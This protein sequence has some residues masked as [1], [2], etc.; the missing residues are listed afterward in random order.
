M[1]LDANGNLRLLEADVTN[2]VRGFLEARA[3]RIIRFQ[4][5]VIPGQFSTH[6][7]GTPDLV[8]IR[9]VESSA[10]PGAA[11]VLWLEL[12]R[13][14]I[15]A[16]CRCATKKARQRCSACDQ[17]LWKERERRRGAQVW[18]IDSIESFINAYDTTF[19]YLHAPETGVGQLAIPLQ[20]SS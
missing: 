1:K 14:G 4:R 17:Q 13:K 5:T 7:P 8:A 6:E 10:V 2:Q 16:Q 15:R 3:W 20:S 9:Y 12:K 18:M 19:S 11:V